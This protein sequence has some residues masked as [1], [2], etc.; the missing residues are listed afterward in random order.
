MQLQIVATQDDDLLGRLAVWLGMTWTHVAL[1]YKKDMP[2]S[3]WRVIEATRRGIIDSSWEEFIADKIEHELFEVRDGLPEVTKREIVAYGRGN[4]GKRYAYWWLAR[5]GW[6]LLRRRFPLGVLTYPSHICS[7]LV[8]NCFLN[9]GIDL[10]LGQ[11]DV[12]PTP[13]QVVSSPLLRK[14]GPEGPMIQLAR[15]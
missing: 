15:G 2:D 13:D 1:R 5:I 6:R 10:L 12:L 4:V 14:T 11:A 3:S 7:S 8:H 9:G